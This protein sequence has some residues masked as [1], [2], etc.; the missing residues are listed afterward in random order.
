MAKLDVD[1]LDD[2]MNKLREL[3]EVKLIPVLKRVVYRG[4]AVV[5][6]EIRQKIS[7]LPTQPNRFL[8]NGDIFSVFTETN[9]RDLLNSLGFSKITD[10]DGGV[11]S[12]VGFAGYGSPETVTQQYPKGLPNALLARSIEHGSSVRRRKAFVKPAV[13]NAKDKAE[14]AMQAVLDEEIDKLMKG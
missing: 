3:G 8:R 2:E 13:K 14:E 5:A 7:E 10:S 9:K 12:Y 4:G 1:G 6:D 11:Y